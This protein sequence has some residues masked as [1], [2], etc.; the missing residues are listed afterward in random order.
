MDVHILP[1]LEDN[2]IF[3]LHNP[4]TQEATVVDPTQSESVVAKLKELGA[5]LK[6]ILNTHQHGDHVG[7]NLSLLSRFPDAKVFASLQ[8]RGRIPGQTDSVNDGD[9]L[10]VLGSRAEVLFVPGHTRG[11]VAYFFPAENGNPNLLFCGDTLFRGGCGKLFEGTFLQMYAS[12]KKIRDLPA[13]TWVYCAHEYSEENYSINAMLEP[14]NP[15]VAQELELIKSMRRA[16]EKT[17]PF[18]LGQECEASPFLRWDDA[19]LQHLLE[20][21]QDPVSTFTKVRE[22]RDKF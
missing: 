14:N 22:F 17:I 3:L 6:A 16:N 8:D 20:T 12:L 18:L 15:R 11:H 7:G 2:Y 5:S 4:A 9:V 13:P 1:A 21:E 10:D 19:V